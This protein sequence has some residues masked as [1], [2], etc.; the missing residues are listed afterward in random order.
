MSKHQKQHHYIVIM[1]DHGYHDLIET[2]SYEKKKTA[3]A[4]G[5]TEPK[6]LVNVSSLIRWCMEWKDMNPE[7]WAIQSHLP[8]DDIRHYIMSQPEEMRIAIRK[9]GNPL[10]RTEK[11]VDHVGR[12]SYY[13]A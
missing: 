1:S 9:K 11:K 13:K 3:A 10:L 5:A 8:K 12:R 4:L 2:T 7:I 6:P